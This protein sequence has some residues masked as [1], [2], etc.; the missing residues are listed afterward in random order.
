M[1]FFLLSLLS[2]YL[3]RS[4]MLAPMITPLSASQRSIRFEASD[5]LYPI[6][7]IF[8]L[9][10]FLCFFFFFFFFFWGGGF[11]VR[12]FDHS[13][14]WI[15]IRINSDLMWPFTQCRVAQPV[16][17]GAKKRTKRERER[18]KWRSIPPALR[19]RQRW[20][21]LLVQQLSLS[22]M[23]CSDRESSNSYSGQPRQPRQL[24]K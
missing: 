1:W 21:N 3:F 17:V 7:T 9:S 18:E 14:S 11:L 19:T 4:V 10:I 23:S 8:S 2:V 22:R 12:W 6:K 20:K 24:K 15:R 5:G 16:K 13:S